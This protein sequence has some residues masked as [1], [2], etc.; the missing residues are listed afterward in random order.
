MAHDPTFRMSR[1]TVVVRCSPDGRAWLVAVDLVG[2][3]AFPS[4]GIIH[5]TVAHRS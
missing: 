5:H 4:G 3:L 1:A 2:K